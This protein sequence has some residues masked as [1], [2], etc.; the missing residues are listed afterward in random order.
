MR[1]RSGHVQALLVIDFG[2]KWAEAHALEVFKD[3]AIGKLR[4]ACGFR[5]GKV[6]VFDPVA[7][8]DAA[9]RAGGRRRSES[10]GD[11]EDPRRR[12]TARVWYEGRVGLRET[13]ILATCASIRSRAATRCSC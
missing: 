13:N 6:R 4:L 10:L 2:D 5:D 1:I 3:L 11:L 9:A 12:A 8:G 7:G